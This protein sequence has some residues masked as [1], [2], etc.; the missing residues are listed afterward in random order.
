MN[1]DRK[2]IIG[3][4]VAL[5]KEKILFKDVIYAKCA[6]CKQSDCKSYGIVVDNI[7]QKNMQI[8][9]PPL[10]ILMNCTGKIHKAWVYEII[11]V[12]SL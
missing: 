5:K 9:V 8:S 2:K 4:L 12:I 11:E 10:V 7:K 1:I 3:S 6:A